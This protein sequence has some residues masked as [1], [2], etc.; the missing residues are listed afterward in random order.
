LA[1]RHWIIPVL[2]LT[3]L[4]K[5]SAPATRKPSENDNHL[6]KNLMNEIATKKFQSFKDLKGA[7]IGVS[8]LT[9]GSTVLLR[10]SVQRSGSQE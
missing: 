10:L 6:R 1:K 8:S 2:V 3:A 7:T 4:Q 9:S 5:W